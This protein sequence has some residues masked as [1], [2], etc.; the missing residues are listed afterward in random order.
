M[1]PLMSDAGVYKCSVSCD[2][3]IYYTLPV[4]KRLFLGVCYE[5][6]VQQEQQMSLNQVLIINH[7][8]KRFFFPPWFNIKNKT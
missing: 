2:C 3:N 1:S 7:A 8:V 6:V 4:K 5:A